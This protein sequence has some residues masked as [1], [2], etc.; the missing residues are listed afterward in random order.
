MSLKLSYNGISSNEIKAF[1]EEKYL[2][3]NNPS[4]IECD[5]ISIPHSFSDARDREISGFLI[6][7]IAW[8]RRDLILRSGRLMLEL[9]DNSPSE[10]ILYANENE[11]SRFSRFVHRTFNGTDCIYFIKGLRHIYS[12]FGSME[13]V[14]LQGMN[15]SGSVKEGLSYLR[16]LFFSLPHATRNEKHFADVT[17]GAAGKRLNMFLRWMVRQDNF[18]VDFGIWK[19]IDPAK[20]YIPLDLHSGNTAR[21]LGL[22]T[23]KMNDWKA[24]EELT[25]ILKEFDPADPV[26]YDFALFGLGVNE[27]F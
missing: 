14:I 5:P 17:G 22:L 26:K 1:L 2:Q 15:D 3:Y 7:A 13:D 8:G 24:V 23:R 20:L 27:K 19:K 10:F 25:G 18:G 21:R 11:L 16:S 6:A 4:F 9:M 12:R